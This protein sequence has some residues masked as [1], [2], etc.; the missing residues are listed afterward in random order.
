[1]DERAKQLCKQLQGSCELQ[2]EQ[3]F[4]NYE[5]AIGQLREY[6][7]PEVLRCMLQCFRDVEAGDGQYMLVHAVE[8]FPVEQYV[9]FFLEE[10]REIFEQAPSWFSLLIHGLLN[11]R[12]SAALVEPHFEQLSP[13][14]KRFYVDYVSRMASESPQYR[15]NAERLAM[16]LSGS[17]D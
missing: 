10:G 4:E 15:P 5:N 11:D 2:V 12:E 16:K 1:M 9:P 7:D 13:A 3:D 17:V 14:D 8:A 6:R